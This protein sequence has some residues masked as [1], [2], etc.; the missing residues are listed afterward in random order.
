MS[1]AGLRAWAP[2]PGQHHDVFRTGLHGLV[3]CRNGVPS[4]TH[5]GGARPPQAMVG[6]ARSEDPF[7]G[8]GQ[9]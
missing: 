9:T 8:R 6:R 2:Y 1:T 3:I 7:S 5:N 4:L